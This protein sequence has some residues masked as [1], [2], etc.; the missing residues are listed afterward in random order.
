M[1]KESPDLTITELPG[2]LYPDLA[3]AQGAALKA[4]AQEIAKIIRD[5]LGAGV[6][7]QVNGRI[8]PANS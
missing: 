8:I 4:T 3:V 5:L 6:L 1:P 7:V 2:D